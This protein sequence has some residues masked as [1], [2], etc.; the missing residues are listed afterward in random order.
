MKL[1]QL[2][3]KKATLEIT[4]QKKRAGMTVSGKKTGFQDVAEKI[5]KQMLTGVGLD[6]SR[7]YAID[8]ETYLLES[9]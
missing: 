7:K 1:A 5:T 6:T 2:G 8:Q 9:L 4:L 3:M